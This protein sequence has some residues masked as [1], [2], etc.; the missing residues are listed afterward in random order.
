MEL[1]GIAWICVGINWI[2][3]F[4]ELESVGIDAISARIEAFV[5]ATILGKTSISLKRAKFDGIA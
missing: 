2:S 4:V 1:L 5:R 3:S